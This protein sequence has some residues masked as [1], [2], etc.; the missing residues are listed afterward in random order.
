MM[1]MTMMNLLGS[2]HS[3][4]LA[5]TER[6]KESKL[7]DD[8]S[9]LSTLTNIEL[10]CAVQTFTVPLSL[11]TY[12]SIN[13][14]NCLWISAFSSFIMFWCEK[15]RCW[16]GRQPINRVRKNPT[17][18]RKTRSNPMCLRYKTLFLPSTLTKT[19]EIC[20]C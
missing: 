6:R 10:L 8:F 14:V 20:K 5:M 9:H 12:D 3:S 16:R 19:K 4:Q 17:R 2:C 13:P 18:Q 1:M 15:E 11:N 7:I